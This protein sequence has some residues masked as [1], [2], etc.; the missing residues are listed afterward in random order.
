VIKRPLKCRVIWEKAV[1]REKV[2]HRK[3]KIVTM[4]VNLDCR[5]WVEQEHGWSCLNSLDLSLNEHT[6]I[7]RS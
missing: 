4:D 3:K 1:R 7:Q 5:G 6:C 2:E